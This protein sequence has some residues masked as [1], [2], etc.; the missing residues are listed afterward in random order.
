VAGDPLP[1]DPV[2]LPLVEQQPELVAGEWM[3]VPIST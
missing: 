2:E 1:A 3:S